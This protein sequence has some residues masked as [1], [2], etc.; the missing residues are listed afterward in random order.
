[1]KNVFTNCCIYLAFCVQLHRLEIFTKG[2]LIPDFDDTFANIGFG[3]LLKSYSSKSSRPYEAWLSNNTDISSVMAALKKYAYRPFSSN[4]DSNSIDPTTFFYMRDFIYSAAESGHELALFTLWIQN[5]SEVKVDYNKKPRMPF[6]VNYVDLSSVADIVYG[7]TA[8]ILN[9]M[10]NPSDWFDEDL[11]HIYND[12]VNLL[13]WEIERNF[14]SRPDLVTSTK[15][16]YFFFWFTSRTLNLLASS[17]PLPFTVMEEVL[18]TLKTAM[19]VHATNSVLKK[20]N[21]DNG[22]DPAV[23]YF[24]DFLGNGD[25]SFLG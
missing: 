14:S 11:Q 21:L 20:A 17:A 24:E 10:Q 8:A 6:N 7:I 23:V 9:N 12:S 4:S 3:S 1:M 22:S 16:L 5:I 18:A 2:N 13:A 19:R 25:I 15:S